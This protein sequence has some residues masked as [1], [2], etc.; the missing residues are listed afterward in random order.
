MRRQQWGHGYHN[1]VT[2]GVDYGMSCGEFSAAMG[3]AEQVNMLVRQLCLVMDTEAGTAVEKWAIIH[4]LFDVTRPHLFDPSRAA[5]PK[6]PKSNP[7]AH[8]TDSPQ[9]TAPQQ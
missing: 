2:D 5:V 7:V 4:T 1:G 3:I 8:R 6:L 9:P